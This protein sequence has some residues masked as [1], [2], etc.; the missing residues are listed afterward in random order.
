MSDILKAISD[1]IAAGKE[2]TKPK[3]EP[4]P[5]A[6]LPKITEGEALRRHGKL[7]NARASAEAQLDRIQARLKKI[8]AAEKDLREQCPHKWGEDQ[9]FP[10]HIYQCEICGETEVV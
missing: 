3:P 1:D 8:R 4:P 10:Y 2:W 6:P 5:R 7:E 9:G